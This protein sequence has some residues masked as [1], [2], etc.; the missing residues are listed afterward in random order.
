MKTRVRNWVVII[1]GTL[2]ALMLLEGM[3][4][5]WRT[6]ALKQITISRQT[7]YITTPLARGGG[8]E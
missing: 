6:D 7:T 3:V 8:V 1:I 2:L 5:L 4:R